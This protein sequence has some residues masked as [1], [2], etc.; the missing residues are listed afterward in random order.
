[1]KLPSAP[2]QCSPSGQS[3][4]L[5]ET[6]IGLQSLLL[7]VLLR[8]DSEALHERPLAPSLIPLLT[9]PSAP[10][11]L[12]LEPDILSPRTVLCCPLCCLI[13]CR[14]LL[15]DNCSKK[16]SRAPLSKMGAPAKPVSDPLSPYHYLFV[17]L[18]IVSFFY[19]NTLHKGRDWA[20][21]HC[22]L[23][24]TWGIPAFQ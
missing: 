23:P 21:S 14:F 12:L 3:Q 10:W 11:L 9:A 1:M 22:F 20:C 24:G 7:P 6:C 18:Y 17:Y 2:L 5:S 8:M 19:Q 4:R 15:E 13:S 16:S